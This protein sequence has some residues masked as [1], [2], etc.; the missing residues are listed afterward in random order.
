MS[1]RPSGGEQ[2]AA[3]AVRF[4]SNCISIQS[5]L[6][7]HALTRK[8]LA[9]LSLMYLLRCFAPRMCMKRQFF[10]SAWERASRGA[11]KN[12]NE[13]AILR[14]RARPRLRS[15]PDNVDQTLKFRVAARSKASDRSA[16]DGEEAPTGPRL[17][18]PDDRLRA[19]SGRCSASPGERRRPCKR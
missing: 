2:L 12:L 19:V 5:R 15:R 18:L 14:S 8:A 10:V 4:M 17:A 13:A 11:F 6:R 16:P 1:C 9:F 3:I 7:S